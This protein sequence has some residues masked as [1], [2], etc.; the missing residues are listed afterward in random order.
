MTFD[1]NH[2]GRL[3]HE[4]WTATKRAQGFH[5]PDAPHIWFPS[6]GTHIEGWELHCPEPQNCRFYHPD[7]IPWE[8]LPAK[9]QDVNLHASD[10]VLPYLQEQMDD[11]L[12][13]A[14]ADAAVLRE[15]VR[16]DAEVWGAVQ[17]V[18]NMH[19]EIVMS[20]TLAKDR[21]E[22]CE[23]ALEGSSQ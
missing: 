21:Q 5:G 2:M 3:M 4:S 11:A 16:R 19:G 8:D 17:K 10:A 14:R 23:Q 7:L 9:Q 6:K 12:A 20:P 18:R 1:L 15:T 22:A 13:K